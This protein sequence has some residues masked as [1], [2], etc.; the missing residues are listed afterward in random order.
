MI[1]TEE[2]QDIADGY[3]LIDWPCNVTYYADQLKMKVYQR[4]SFKDPNYL[5]IRIYYL[6]K[7][8][9]HY[10]CITWDFIS[11]IFDAILQYNARKDIDGQKN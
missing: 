2:Q 7:F 1:T 3:K 5:D 9:T 10:F 6:N 4:P 11:V 8:L